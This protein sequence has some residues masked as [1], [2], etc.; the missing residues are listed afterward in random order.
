MEQSR[1][2]SLDESRLYGCNRGVRKAPKF[3]KFFWS[4]DVDKKAFGTLTKPIIVC[5]HF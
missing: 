5:R 1:A 2:L 4:I 3:A